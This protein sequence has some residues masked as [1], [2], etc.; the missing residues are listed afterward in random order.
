MAESFF[1]VKL[2]QS[3]IASGVDGSMI[4]V[5][6]LYK[7]QMSKVCFSHQNNSNAVFY[8]IFD[9]IILILYKQRPSASLCFKLIRNLSEMILFK[10]HYK[11][12]T[13]SL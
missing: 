13:K 6:T 1:I 8:F 11:L 2:I 9:I 3:L 4:G 7:S 10:M 12:K 5:I